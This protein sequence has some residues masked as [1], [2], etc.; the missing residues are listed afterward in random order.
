VSARR[1]TFLR[2]LA[3]GLVNTLFGYAVYALLVLGGVPPQPALVVAFAVGVVWNYV[4][5][6]RFVFHVRGYRRL[7]AYAGLYLLLYLLNAG[8]LRLALSEGVP[9]LLAQA[10]LTPPMAILSF[11]LLSLAM[12]GRIGGTTGR[13]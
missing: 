7:P 5:S 2:F 11:A 4:T 10:V 12:T 3:A 8:A 9:P 6:A 1:R 13:G